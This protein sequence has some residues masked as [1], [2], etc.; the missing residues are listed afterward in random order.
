[1]LYDKLKEYSLKGVY[2]MHMPGH[3]R[4]SEALLPGLPY[5]IDITEIHGFDDLHVP[6]GILLETSQL[7]ASLYGSDKAFL[8]VNG[9]TVGIISAIGA[10]T[11]RGDKILIAG[12]CHWSVTNAATLFGLIPVFLPSETDYESGVS[13]SIDPSAVESEI[14]KEQN[15]RL[16]VVTSPSYEGIVSDISSIA[17]VS[18][19]CGIPLLVDSAHGAHLGFSKKFPVSAVT[20][21]ADVVVM[22]LHKTLPA[23]TQCSLMHVSGERV[24]HEEIA[25]MLSVLQTSSPSYVLMASIDHCLRLLASDRERLFNEYE[26]N[27]EYFAREIAS[28]KNLFVLGNARLFAHDPGKIVIVTKNTALSGFELADILRSENKIELERACAEYAI[29]MTSICD[30]KEG[31]TR[32]AKALREIDSFQFRKI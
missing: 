11:T 4:N 12:A 21:G 26:Q 25:R 32:L 8:L 3:K 23:L 7:A 18:Q 30:S 29:A 20:A 9:S 17:D 22:S 28:L 15:I 16:I 13:L 10:L 31:F 24:S 5:D 14:E 27:L 2:P 1:M 6:R 19:S